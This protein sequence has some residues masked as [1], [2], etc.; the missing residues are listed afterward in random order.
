MKS[1]HSLLSTRRNFASLDIQKV[2]SEDSDQ[3]ARLV[4]PQPHNFHGDL[5]GNNFYPLS[6]D[7]RRAVVSYWQKYKYKVLVNCLED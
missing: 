1:D 3:T 2:P 6:A 4:P 5:P 7:S